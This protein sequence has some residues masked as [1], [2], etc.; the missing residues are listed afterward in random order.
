MCE[1]VCVC[2]C[3]CVSVC[4]PLST[5]YVNIIPEPKYR[6]TFYIVK[7][8][9]IIRFITAIPDRIQIASRTDWILVEFR[10][11]YNS[12]EISSFVIYV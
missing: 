6:G 5:F 9:E 11:N 8:I 7:R 2:V 10:T 3:V 12:D 4:A 1:C